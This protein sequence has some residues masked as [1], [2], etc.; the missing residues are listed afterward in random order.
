MSCALLDF[1]SSLSIMSISTTRR[2]GF[3]GVYD[4][5]EAPGEEGDLFEDVDGDGGASH[6][7]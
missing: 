5:R 4:G 3:V 2:D 6:Y 1:V 7:D